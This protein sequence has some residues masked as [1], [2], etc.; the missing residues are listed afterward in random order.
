MKE[1]QSQ[2]R[3][4]SFGTGCTIVHPVNIYECEIGDSCF[5]GPFV[6][7]Q[8]NVLI[9]DRTK[10][11]SHSFI[12]EMVHIGNDCFIGHGVMFINDV[13]SKGKPAGGDSTQWKKTKIGNNVSIGS[14]ATIL[15]VEIADE[16]VIGAGA[17]VTKDIL[18]KGVYAGNPA[19][20]LRDL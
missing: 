13:F 8:N 10:V 1:Y 3:K 12:C 15:P 18:T 6:E 16:T 19:R 4:V 9:G 7:I 17:V 2:V 14:N 11:Q 5:V 20:K